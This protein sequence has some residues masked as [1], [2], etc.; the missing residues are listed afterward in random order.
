MSSYYAV[1]HLHVHS[2]KTQVSTC[3]LR[4][5]DAKCELNCVWEGKKLPYTTKPCYLG[6]TLVRLLSFG[7]QKRRLQHKII[8]LPKLPTHNG[9]HQQLHSEQQRLPCATVPQ[10]MHAQCGKDHVMHTSSMPPSMTRVTVS[11]GV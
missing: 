11:L 9:V 1:N 10:S 6:V 2:S 4:T 5:K 7:K 3:H 8:S